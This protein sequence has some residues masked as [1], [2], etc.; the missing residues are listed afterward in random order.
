MKIK[1]LCLWSRRINTQFLYHRGKK[2]N[3]FLNGW[4]NGV[5]YF[6]RLSQKSWGLHKGSGQKGEESRSWC[7]EPAWEHHQHM[8]V[9]NVSSS[10]TLH[11]QLLPQENLISSTFKNIYSDFQELCLTSLTSFLQEDG[12]GA[13]VLHLKWEET[14]LW[15]SIRSPKRI[16]WKIFIIHS[17]KKT[18]LKM[19]A[20][21]R[22][23]SLF[24]IFS[25][26]SYMEMIWNKPKFWTWID[27][28]IQEKTEIWAFVD[29]FFQPG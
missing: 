9:P 17:S 16:L 19:H 3:V 15:S 29:S 22:S 23:S 18:F 20:V 13:L 4:L 11:S 28:K 8:R 10:W 2:A 27:V 14:C 26:F 7:L 1:Y 6:S 5:S 24:N 12:G 25:I 21:S